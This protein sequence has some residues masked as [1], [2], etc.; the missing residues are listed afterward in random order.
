MDAKVGDAAAQKNTFEPSSDVIQEQDCDTLLIYLPGFR[1]EQLRVQLAKSGTVRVS[2]TRPIGDNKLSIFQKDYHVSPNCDTTNI[3]A[4][5]EG[6]ILYIRQPKL[7]VPA[8][9]EAEK[10]PVLETQPA[11]RSLD[12]RPPTPIPSRPRKDQE[13]EDTKKT[14]SSEAQIKQETST[15]F[16]DKPDP[17]EDA[18][19]VE[20]GKVDETEDDK[21]EKTAGTILDDHQRAE[22][23]INTD[24]REEFSGNADSEFA[25]KRT[26][27]VGKDGVDYYKLVAAGTAAKVIKSKK[28]VYMAMAI[29]LAF[30]FGMYFN[31]LIWCSNKPEK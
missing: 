5:F 2:G 30:A 25:Y 13:N 16:R 21:K 24:R 12:H 9:K 17:K 28:V 20:E 4:K 31:N 7:I 3:S 18:K 14:S 27:K 26:G 22:P 8:E 19:P 10:S 11:Q 15:G 6:G 23:S 1:R 29:V